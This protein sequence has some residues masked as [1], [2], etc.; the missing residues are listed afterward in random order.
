MRLN[1]IRYLRAMDMP[2]PDIKRFLDTE[3]SIDPRN[4]AVELLDAQLAAVESRLR[5]LHVIHEKLAALR[6]ASAEGP[7]SRENILYGLSALA[8]LT[9]T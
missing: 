2:L 1:F 4:D 9:A 7:P 6:A 8:G 3:S 5:T